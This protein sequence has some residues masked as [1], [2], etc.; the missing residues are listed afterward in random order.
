MLLLCGNRAIFSSNSTPRFR[1]N[2]AG[3]TAESPT[4]KVLMLTLLSCCF[5]PII[6]NS[7]LMSLIFIL[8]MMIHARIAFI[9]FSMAAIDSSSVAVHPGLKE[10]Y[11]CVCHLRTH[12]RREG[13]FQWP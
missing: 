13:T 2:A 3:A 9:Q 11:S 8:S 6:R 4:Y 1:A 7:A 5:V 12:V 10:R